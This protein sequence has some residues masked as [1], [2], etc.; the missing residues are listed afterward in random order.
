[1][2][3]D[4]ELL[5]LHPNVVLSKSKAHDY[6]FTKMRGTYCIVF[7]GNY[8]GWSTFDSIIGNDDSVSGDDLLFSLFFL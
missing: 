2:I 1:M 7:H 6:F 8:G 3:S 4:E 5:K